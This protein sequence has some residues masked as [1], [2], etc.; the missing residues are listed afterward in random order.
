MKK[1]VTIIL[2]FILLIGMLKVAYE[3]YNQIY[4]DGDQE[5]A[6][7]CYIDQRLQPM[8]YRIQTLEDK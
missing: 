5:L 4:P 3:I 8:E 6:T 7:K 2:G 1:I